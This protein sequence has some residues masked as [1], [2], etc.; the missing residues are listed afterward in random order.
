MFLL[1]FC[2]YPSIDLCLLAVQ[3]LLILKFPFTQAGPLTIFIIIFFYASEGGI[4]KSQ[5]NLK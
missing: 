1:F 2:L 3:L 4:I 5:S